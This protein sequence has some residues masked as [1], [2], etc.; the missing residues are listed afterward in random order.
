MSN[1]ADLV[2]ALVGSP[3]GASTGLAA[4]TTVAVAW[5]RV[6]TDMQE[7]RGLS[8]PEQ[9]REIRQYAEREGIEIVEE[10][11][12]ACSA[13]QRYEKRVEFHRMLA[14]VEADPR[15]NAIVTHDFSRF[16]RDT[17][18]AMSLVRKLRASGVRVISVNDPEID[19]ESVAGVYLEAITFAKNEAFSR[20]IAFHTRKGCRANVKTR[21]EETGWCYKNGGQPLW[22]FRIR[23]LTRGQERSG[24]PIIKSI[25]ELDDTLVAGRPV[26][27]WTR[28]CLVELAAEGASLHELRDFCNSNGI[29]GR[30]KSHWGTSTWNALL[31]PHILLKYCGYEVWNVRRKNGSIR[32]PS[33]WTVVENA[34]PAIITEKGVAKPPFEQSLAAFEG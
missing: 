29:P 18:R 4:P 26:H 28:H 31:L 24:R 8:L 12:E 14:R 3:E 1:A 34:H 19:P 15:I 7:E 21:D 27:E 23:R 25:W 16:S 9:L 17:V 33:E 32:P 30:R 2:E 5:A 13:F 10:F 6:S 20:E 22:G 11:H